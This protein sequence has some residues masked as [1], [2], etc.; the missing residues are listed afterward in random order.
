L[1]KIKV[2]NKSNHIFSTA[3]RLVKA[4]LELRKSR[5]QTTIFAV[6]EAGLC[7]PYIV[8][9]TDKFSYIDNT[10]ELTHSDTVDVRWIN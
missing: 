8:I 7:R 1:H 9:Y 5:G 3:A 2:T 6:L 4:H 10:N